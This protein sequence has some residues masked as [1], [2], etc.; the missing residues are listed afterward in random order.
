LR[1][2]K[3]IKYRSINHHHGVVFRIGDKVI[4]NPI[5][6]EDISDTEGFGQFKN[7]IVFT[8]SDLLLDNFFSDFTTLW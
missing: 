8:Y 1:N 5:R 3:E 6:L 4:N 2:D 7:I